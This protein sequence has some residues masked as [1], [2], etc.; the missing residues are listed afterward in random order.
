MGTACYQSNEVIKRGKRGIKHCPTTVKGKKTHQTIAI[1]EPQAKNKYKSRGSDYTL[2]VIKTDDKKESSSKKIKTNNTSNDNPVRMKN[3]EQTK[4][5]SYTEL[6]IDDN[7]YV[8]CPKCKAIAFIREFN[9]EDNI[10]D[11]IVSYTCECTNPN[12]NVKKTHLINLINVNNTPNLWNYFISKEGADEMFKIAKQKMNAF[13]GYNILEQL[14][15]N[16]K[17]NSSVAPPIELVN[18]LKKKSIKNNSS[19]VS[20]SLSKSK[21]TSSY[22]IQISENVFET[23][24]LD[25]NL[26]ATQM[27]SIKEEENEDIKEYYCIKTLHGHK[28]RVV[29]LIQLHSGLIATGSYDSTIR[30]WN[31][32]KSSCV[33]ML[34]DKGNQIYCLLEFNPELLLFGN[35]ANT[36]GLWDL[37]SEHNIKSYS[38]SGH[39]KWVNCLVKCDDNCFASASNDGT[40][41]I[42]N[43]Y[44]KRCI[45]TIE[46]HEDSVLCIIKLI[47]GKLCSGGADNLIKIWNWN[48]GECVYTIPAHNNWVKS[49]CQLENGQLLSGSDDNTIKIW[50]D[51]ENSRSL[52]GHEHGVR[53]ICQINNNYIAS[54]S[55][56]NTIK[57]WNL[58]NLECH[59]TLLGHKSNV[60]CVIQLNNNNLAS[61]STDY[62]IKIWGTK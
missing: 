49:L 41:K 37:N 15:K 14:I 58:N 57:I 2:P 29:S 19:N 59:Q 25:A 7:L 31:V 16:N 44:N 17:F 1:E 13:K 53:S 3:E 34:E 39:D 5:K 50:E 26:K 60:I 51:N 11:F 36:I 33:K 61:C 62:T 48:N 22:N 43:Y 18:D 54:G 52:I 21:A 32:E 20:T 24:M 10:N 55:F 45:R 28:D 4:K 6:R 35:S 38:F 27:Q 42:W 9:Y 12:E 23:D 40:I 47:D 46:A 30:I 8:V 56:D